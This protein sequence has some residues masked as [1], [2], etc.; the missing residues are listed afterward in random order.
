MR[1]SR[2]AI[3]NLN[4]IGQLEPLVAAGEFCVILKTGAR[5]NMTCSL[6]ELQRRMGVA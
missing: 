5:L 2:S 1:I 6:S 3:V 4:R